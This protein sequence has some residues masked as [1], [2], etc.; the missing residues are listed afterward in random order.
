VAVKTKRS[1]SK[2]GSCR[3]A[4]ATRAVH[5]TIENAGMLRDV[6][7]VDYDRLVGTRPVGEFHVCVEISDRTIRSIAQVQ[8]LLPYAWLGG[9]RTAPRQPEISQSQSRQIAARE[10]WLHPEL[11]TS[12]STPQTRP[13]RQRPDE[14]ILTTRMQRP[15]LAREAVPP[16]STSE[17]Y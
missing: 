1:R 15:Q 8:R 12:Q 5:R 6:A 16:S 7:L 10:S 2:E 14:F 17:Q 11:S 3:S 13:S 4:P 9:E